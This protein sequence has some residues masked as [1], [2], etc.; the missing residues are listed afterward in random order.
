MFQSTLSLIAAAAAVLL[1][2]SV[3]AG[4][5]AA[6]TSQGAQPQAFS[7]ALKLQKTYF[8]A[9]NGFGSA[10]PAGSSPYGSTHTINCTVTA[11]CFVIVHTNV[12][13]AG[14]ASVNPSAIQVLVDGVVFD[15]PYNTPVSTTSYTVMN[16]QTGFPLTT[17]TH[18]V[19]VAVYASRATTLHRYNTEIKLYR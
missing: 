1:S 2:Q 14:G 11:G 5:D 9:G 7:A 15:G 3:Q 19:S 12:Q 13:V 18:T 8:E 17:G 4:A 16:Y 10:L 6:S